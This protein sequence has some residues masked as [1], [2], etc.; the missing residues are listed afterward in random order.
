[1]PSHTSQAADGGRLTNDH[2]W[3]C[4]CGWRILQTWLQK[5]AMDVTTDACR[6][7]P[8]APAARWHDEC[9][10]NPSKW[11]STR[12][13]GFAEV[14]G[15]RLRWVELGELTANPPPRCFMGWRTVL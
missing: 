2:D 9:E 10:A 11:T 6:G 7:G 13:I 15:C 12:V 5:L 3:Q 4:A 1:V 14:E 8:V